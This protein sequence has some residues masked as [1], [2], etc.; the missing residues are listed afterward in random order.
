MY[1][2]GI[3]FGG[4]STKLALV[5]ADGRLLSRLG[6]PARPDA[7]ADPLF[8]EL[9]AIL[10][11]M[12]AQAGLPFPPPGGAGIGVAGIVDVPA[13]RVV[14]TGALGMRGCDVQVAAERALGCPVAIESDSNAGALAD[15]YFG[16]ARGASDVLYLSW[17]S[18]IGAGLVVGGRLLRSQGGAAGE[19]GHA[20]VER[21]SPR[22]CYC[23]CRGCLEIEAGGRAIAERAG[24]RLGRPVTVQDV[25]A[26]AGSDAGCLEILERAAACVARALSSA[27]VLLDP[28]CVV[29]GGG[30]SL[31]L[32][33]PAVRAALDRELA[34]CLPRFGR[35]PLTVTLSAFGSSAG[36]V[37]AA[38]LPRHRVEEDSRHGAS[39]L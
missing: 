12:A 35:R 33:T 19:I 21:D 2:A 39:R 38:L 32:E 15:L 18:G 10:A 8:N 17:G 22:R 1:S 37:G 24:E 20:P 25:V 34:R 14:L 4:T 30:V 27:V 6:V 28:Q 5:G 29:L 36:V 31:I 11:G 13:G 7:D 26:A 23:G 3:D 16:S 9:A